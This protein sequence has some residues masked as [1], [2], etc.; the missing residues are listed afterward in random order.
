[1]RR[2]DRLFALLQ[3]LR[4]G[5]T[6]TAAWLADRLEVSPRTI[7][8][9]ILDLQSHGVPIDG[10]RGL[11]YLLRSD[12]FLP[13]LALT[14]VENEAIRWGLALAA[15]H[16]DEAI[17]AAAQ[18]VLT[19]LS[20]AVAPFS[21]PS[22]LSTAQRII[23]QTIREALAKSIELQV[24]YCDVHGTESRR[25]LQPIGL[26]HWGKVWTITA[27][28]TLRMDFRVFRLDR[29]SSCQTGSRFQP[30]PG[31]GLAGFLASLNKGEDHGCAQDI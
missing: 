26:D 23:L 12:Y 5:R 21:A 11:G 25:T 2:A 22:S 29:I 13:P 1:M 16:G 15:A 8:R 20:L 10:E 28:C 19:K 14:A 24:V 7:Y 31:R 9:D 30:E 17:A 3:A 27:W 18:D 6:R 4:G